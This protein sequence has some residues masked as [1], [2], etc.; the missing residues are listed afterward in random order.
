MMASPISQTSRSLPVHRQRAHLWHSL[1]STGEYLRCPRR[2][3]YGY[4]ERLPQDRHVPP[5]WRFGSVVHAG[6]EAAY[7]L[8]AEQ[9]ERPRRDCLAAASDAIGRCW[10]EL[11]LP[12]DDGR[13]RA[14]WVV[15]RALTKG[16]LR[17]RQIRGVE[18][19]LR[20]R[21]SEGERIVGFADLILD[22][23]TGTIE[24]VDHKVTRRPATPQM[25]CEDRQLNLYGQLARGMWDDVEVV[26]ASHHYPLLAETVTVE[27][28][29]TNMAAAER[30][31]REVAK[32]IRADEAFLA[33]P[34]EHCGH[35]PWQ[36]SCP[37]GQEE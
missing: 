12:D 30:H 13:Q 9:P 18:V 29:P 35:C 16:T 25:L 14:Q 5:G 11:E 23:D 3:A 1:S 24:I 26:Y 22:R 37:E 6:L 21:I 36:P 31:I 28:D 32:R 17:V 7:R 19:A 15:G 4:V 33:T 20:G 27:L 34:G 2:Y 8:Q 10:R